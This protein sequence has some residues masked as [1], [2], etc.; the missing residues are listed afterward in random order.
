[1]PEPHGA[2]EPSD[3]LLNAASLLANLASEIHTGLDRETVVHRA[4]EGARQVFG[5]RDILIR[6]VD[7]TGAVVDTIGSWTDPQHGEAIGTPHPGGLTAHAISSREAVFSTDPAGDPRVAP[8][9]VQFG[10]RAIATLP[11][12][13]RHRCLGDRKSVV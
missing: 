2:Q 4:L 8:A 13:G 9:N 3:P 12:L 10:V 5:C 11:L 7:D 1:M 6:L